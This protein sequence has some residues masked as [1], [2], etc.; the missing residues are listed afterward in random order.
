MN[1]LQ[2]LGTLELG[3]I[4]GLVAIGVYLTSRVINFPDL[5]VDGSFPLGAAVAAALI[6]DGMNPWLASLFAFLS[7]AISGCITGYL[8]VRWK[9][10]GLLAGIL[11]MTGLYS[12]NLRI[13][14]RPNIS[15]LNEET[16]FTQIFGSFW[17]LIIIC[18]ILVIAVVFFLNTQIGLAI[19]AT[20]ANSKFASAQGVRT[21]WMIVLNLALSNGIVALA[22]ALFAQAQGFAD[23]SAG[24]GT[25]VVGLASLIIGESIFRTRNLSLIIIGCLTGSIIYRLAIAF[26]LNTEFLGLKAADLKLITAVLIGITMILPK[27]KE[28]IL[29]R[30]KIRI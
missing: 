25:L 19:R 23:I 16:I 1:L 8:N 24:A 3:L 21:G 5:T 4:Y 22:G 28:E 27:L 11:T 15:L 7:G 14:G 9:I 26:A 13:M 18:L 17:I 6:V 12:I 20:G 29:S 2:F 30:R 10:M